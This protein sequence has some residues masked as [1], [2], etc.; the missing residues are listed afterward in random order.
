[1]AYTIIHQEKCHIVVPYTQDTSNSF[2]DICQRYGVQVHFKGRTTLVNLLVSPKDKDNITKKSSVI[3]WC[4]CDMI[5]C[6]DEYIRE[7]SRMFGE[8]YKKYL[9]APS[10]FLSTRTTLATHH[11]WSLQNHRQGGHNMARSS[12]ETMYRRVNNPTLNRNIGKYNLPHL[13]DGELHSI[14]ELKIKK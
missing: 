5:D 10:P 8:R 3:Y 13:W 14:P 4:R 2:K 6:E 12:K 7:S 9:K 11:L 1:M